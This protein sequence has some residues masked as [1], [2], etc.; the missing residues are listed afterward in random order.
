MA[1][2]IQSMAKSFAHFFGADFIVRSLAFDRQFETPLWWERC[3]QPALRRQH[4]RCDGG[5]GVHFGCGCC[6]FETGFHLGGIYF[7]ISAGA[8]MVAVQIL[9]RRARHEQELQGDA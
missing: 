2:S 4:L 5:L 1:R 3:N 8:L 6:Y 9:G 7:R